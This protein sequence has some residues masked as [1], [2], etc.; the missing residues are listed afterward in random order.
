MNERSRRL[1]LLRIGVV[2]LLVLSGVG[3]IACAPD[4]GE[5]VLTSGERL[6]SCSTTIFGARVPSTPADSDTNA[7]EVGAKFQTTQATTIQGVRFYK[8]PGNTGTHTGKLYTRDGSLLASAV[9]TNETASGWQSVL[10]STPVAVTANTTYVA[11]YHAPA[12]KYAGD[13]DGFAK[14][15]VDSTG[16]VRALADGAD[17]GN[18]VYRYGS[19]GFPNQTWHATNYYVDV[20][21]TVPCSQPAP[22]PTTPPAPPPPPPTT[23]GP[24]IYVAQNSQ[25]TGNGSSCANAHPVSW[26][27]SGTNWGTGANQLGPGV[28]AVLCG[29]ITTGLTFQGSGSSGK[30]VAIDGTGATVSAT[31]S[32]PNQSW[33]K[34]QNVTWSTG[35]NDVL[36]SMTGGSNG[37]VSGNH[38]D[39][40]SGDPAVWLG[41][42]NGQVLPSNITISNNYIR[43]TA[44]ELGDVQLDMIK[45]EGSRD[46]TIEGNYL[47]MRAGGAGGNA[48]DDV[49]QT[50]EKGG[51][52]G[53][54]P[55]NWTVRYNRIVMNSAAP[56]DRS[57]GMLEGLTGTNQIYGNVF[58]GLSGAGE[59]NGI[60]IDGSQS[61]AV[62]NIFNNTNINA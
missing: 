31:I 30:Y 59:A 45:T 62:F 50:Y 20:I 61:G 5:P 54:A 42:Y 38:A 34:V 7:V 48:H 22:P 32:V 39:G 13:T 49:L 21:A 43:T 8:G 10:F 2:Q 28:T 37:V 40:V 52:S 3:L 15:A 58:L 26:F 55:G 35:F 27:N 25:G 56:N 23:T 36:V 33:W 44:S 16:L 41:Q 60:A 12:G 6:A 1:G 18:G 46:V 24:V 51:A 11:S 14:A 47:E 53:G 29:T 19:G 4:Q 57:W 9:F 17:G